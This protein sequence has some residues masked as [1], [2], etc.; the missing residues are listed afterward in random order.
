M[1]PPYRLEMRMQSLPKL[2]TTQ[3]REL[4]RTPSHC[5]RGQPV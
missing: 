2:R 1:T 5:R 4:R 3:V